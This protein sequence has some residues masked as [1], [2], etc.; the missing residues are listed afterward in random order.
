M[1]AVQAVH[2]CSTYKHA[3][4]AFNGYAD[5]IKNAKQCMLDK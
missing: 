3:E 1:S 5:I 4:R 2:A